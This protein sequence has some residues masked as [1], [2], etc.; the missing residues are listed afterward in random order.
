MIG[1]VKITFTPLRALASD[2]NHP[3][4][5]RD[6]FF[7]QA[8]SI[9][10]SLSPLQERYLVRLTRP[11]MQISLAGL[12]V[13]DSARTEREHN[14]ICSAKSLCA[15]SFPSGFVRPPRATRDYAERASEREIGRRRMI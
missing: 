8:R 9:P 5:V 7:Q 14:D 12:S 4:E 2:K 10:S 6:D 15:L 1:N 13:S 3:G 11:R